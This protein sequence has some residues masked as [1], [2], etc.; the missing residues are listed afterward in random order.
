MNPHDL[1]C[2]TVDRITIAADIGVNGSGVSM[3]GVNAIVAMNTKNGVTT[4]ITITID[5]CRL[6]ER[7]SGFDQAQTRD[8]G[9]RPQPFRRPPITGAATGVHPQ[10]AQTVQA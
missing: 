6:R 10:C 5:V 4:V 9:R 1:S 2:N 7:S 3:N 8:F